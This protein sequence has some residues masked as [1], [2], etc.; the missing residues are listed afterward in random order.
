[1]SKLSLIRRHGI[2]LACAVMAIAHAHAAPGIWRCGNSYSDAP[3]A[4]GKPIE[5]DAPPSVERRREA[6]EATRRD[7]AAAQRMQRERLRLEAEQRHRHAIVIAA[8]AAPPPA[9]PKPASA[10]KK[11]LA[12]SDAFVASYAGADAKDKPAKKKKKPKADE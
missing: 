10:K 11:K 8:P 7:M 1:M 3:C 12:P 9:Q 6:D 2:A 5:A 4:E